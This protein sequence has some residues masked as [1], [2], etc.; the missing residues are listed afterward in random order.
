M[1]L[2]GCDAGKWAQPMKLRNETKR[3]YGFGA[4]GEI[5][6]FGL[7]SF[8]NE[9]RVISLGVGRLCARIGPNPMDIS[10]IRANPFQTWPDMEMVRR[11]PN[12][13]E[14]ELTLARTMYNFGQIQRTTC[15]NSSGCEATVVDG[16]S[17]LL[18]MRS[19]SPWR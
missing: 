8:L 17:W 18:T 1:R 9:A 10:R 12:S 13:L 7:S 4:G 14:F 2:L 5:R 19:G 6:H 3:K 16:M 15:A 11:L